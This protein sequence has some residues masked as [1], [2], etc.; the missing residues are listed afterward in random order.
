MKL[1][2]IKYLRNILLVLVAGS[3][4][5]QE[6]PLHFSWE[7]P[8]PKVATTGFYNIALQPA[9]VAK[10]S[11]PELANF[12]VV[13]GGQAQPCL[14]ERM[15][16]IKSRGNDKNIALPAA[17]TDLPDPVLEQYTDNNTHITGLTL[18]LKEPYLVG[19]LT[20]DIKSPALYH[21]QVLLQE[22]IPAMR[23]KKIPATTRTLASFYLSSDQPPSVV[24]DEPIQ[25]AGIYLEVINEDNPPLEITAVHA[26]QPSIWL[27]AYLEKD[28][29]YA[30]KGGGA[31]MPA[32]KF[33]LEYFSKDVPAHLQVID[34]G[35][36]HALATDTVAPP[37]SF[38]NSEGWIW[39]GIIGIVLLLAFVARSVL[40]DMH[41]E[42]M[43]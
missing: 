21:R 5:A 24:L 36:I 13:K 15:D 20:F 41:K 3:A 9:M 16:T 34:H 17:F 2:M 27:T 29:A 35:A 4:H 28:Q 26:W 38:F 23:K 11:Y 22:R 1:P 33:D 6:Q 31:D 8:L 40:K 39:A 14:V 25:A 12:R 7:A 19:K 32:G 42:Q 10:L 43:R 18:S 37:S 30:I